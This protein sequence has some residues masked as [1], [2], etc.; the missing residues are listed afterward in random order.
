MRL[1]FRSRSYEVEEMHG[2][3]EESKRHGK[4]R[5]KDVVRCQNLKGGKAGDGENPNGN[6]R[7]KQEY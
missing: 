6:D 3:C 7:E 2:Q 4:E 5:P 1:Y